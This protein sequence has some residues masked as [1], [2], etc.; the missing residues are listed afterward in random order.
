MTVLTPIA[1]DL[2][3]RSFIGASEADAG[4]DSIAVS[5]IWPS[6]QNTRLEVHFSVNVNEMPDHLYQKFF[7]GSGNKSHLFGSINLKATYERCYLDAKKNCWQVRNG[8]AVITP[9]ISDGYYTKLVE[10]ANDH[11]GIV[12]DF[13]NKK[14]DL[15]DSQQLSINCAFLSYLKEQGLKVLAQSVLDKVNGCQDAAIAT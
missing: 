3:A 4:H 13:D 7:W 9:R 14:V 1:I 12:N 6:E 5:F 10:I 11:L 15:T 2:A 8:W